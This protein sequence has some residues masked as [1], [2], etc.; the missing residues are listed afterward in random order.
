[1]NLQQLQNKHDNESTK[2]HRL[3]EAKFTNSAIKYKNINDCKYWSI[4]KV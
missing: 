3:T 1:M 2:G 4:K